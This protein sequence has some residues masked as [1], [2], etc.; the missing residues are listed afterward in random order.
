MHRVLYFLGASLLFYT[1]W[2][3]SLGWWTTNPEERQAS[4][5]FWTQSTEIRDLAREDL[6]QTTRPVRHIAYPRL[7]AVVLLFSLLFAVLSQIP[8]KLG[9]WGGLLLA[10]AV[11]SR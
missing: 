10:N 9:L 2:Y 4:I 8:A 11:L 1:M 3:A 7:V 6:Q 5:H